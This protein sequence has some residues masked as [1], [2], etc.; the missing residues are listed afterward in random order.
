LNVTPQPFV[1]FSLSLLA[2]GAG[3]SFVFQQ[4]VNANLRAEIGSPWWAGFISY[5]GGTLVMLAVSLVL[6]E[7]WLTGATIARTSWMSWT[8]GIF[9]AIYI[10]ISILLL[11]R[12]GAAVVVALIVLGQMLAALAFDHFALLGVPENPISPLRLIGAGLL[13]AGVVVIRL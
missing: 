4:A 8:G 9:G 1:I 3:V 11:P 6:R 7:P 10:A 12:L 5:L 13:V 2:A